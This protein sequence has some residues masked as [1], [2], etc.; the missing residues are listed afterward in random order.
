MG[1]QVGDTELSAPELAPEDVRRPD[2]LHG[3]PEDAAHG[4]GGGSWGW[5]WNGGEV[6]YRRTG[7]GREDVDGAI[8]RAVVVRDSAGVAGILLT[9]AVAH[10][11]LWGACLVNG[12]QGEIVGVIYCSVFVNTLL[13]GCVRN[14]KE[15]W[16]VRLAKLP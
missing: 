13:A 12:S 14:P 10:F 16:W 9:A 3:P 7:I 5:G 11:W 2:V 1:H 6:P 4:G 15:V 8:G